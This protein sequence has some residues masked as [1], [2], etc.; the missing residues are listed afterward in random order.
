VDFAAMDFLLRAR[1]KLRRR[2]LIEDLFLLALRTFAVLFFILALARPGN[3]LAQTLT[4]RPA[5]GVVLLLDSTMSMHHRHRGQSSFE[6]GIQEG[7]SLLEGLEESQGDQAAFILAGDP[8]SREAFGNPTKVL[9]SLAEQANPSF[10]ETELAEAATWALRSAEALAAEGCEEVQISFLTDLQSSTWNLDDETRAAFLRLNESGFPLRIQDVGASKRENTAITRIEVEP[11]RVAPGEMAEVSVTVRHFSGDDTRTN[12]SLKHVRG[13]LFLD[14]SPV[15]DAELEIPWNGESSWVHTLT[16]A[17]LGSRSLEFRLDSDALVP[18]DHRATILNVAPSPTVLI[19]GETRSNAVQ[20]SL[21]RFLDFP[22]PAPLTIQQ[23][24]ASALNP[25]SLARTELLILADPAQVTTRVQ[26][27]IQKFV[28]SG[29]GFLLAL[30]SEAHAA[31]CEELLSAL[32][33]PAIQ[34][35]EPQRY[36]N[37][38]ARLAIQNESWPPLSLFKDPRWKPLLTEIPVYSFRP[39]SLS[40]HPSASLI[41]AP[42]LLVRDSGENQQAKLSNAI[43]TWQ[44]DGGPIAVFSTPPLPDWNRFE[45]VPGG[46]LPFL[47]DLCSYLANGTSKSTQFDVGSPLQMVLPSPP[48]DLQLENPIGE[49]LRPQS[50]AEPYG[51]RFVQPLLTAASLPGVWTSSAQTVRSDGNTL[52]HHQKFSVVVPE[53]ESKLAPVPRSLLEDILPNPESSLIQSN[54]FNKEIEPSSSED[55]AP[56][57]FLIVVL[58]LGTETLLAAFLDRRRG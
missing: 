39:L 44:L 18:D 56:L 55:A 42:L 41:Q 2:L 32:G 40:A 25:T 6:R 14:N 22:A 3:E 38:S 52:Q 8:I 49:R 47:F 7:T 43:L 58:L 23:V 53:S 15:A 19:L 12:A 54:A 48:V 10:G 4:G 50:E 27:L 30:G 24:S 5:R 35:E 33:A 51:A 20:E 45:E 1:K 11:G 28:A 13:Q 9:L 31:D 16:P 26:E 37:P 29:G 17:E 21:T 46:T 57:L 34:I 36:S